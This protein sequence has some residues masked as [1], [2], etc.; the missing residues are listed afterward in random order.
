M[1][2]ALVPL[3]PAEKHKRECLV[4]GRDEVARVLVLWVVKKEAQ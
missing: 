2:R 1:D 3:V 4:I